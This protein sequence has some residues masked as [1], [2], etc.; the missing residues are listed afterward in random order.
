V[1]VA[2]TTPEEDPSPSADAPQATEAP[3]DTPVPELP[4]NQRKIGDLV[5]TV[6]GVAPYVDD[7]FPAEAGTHYVAVDITGENVGDSSYGLNALNFR[8]QDS[9]GFAN[10]QAVTQGPEPKIS[11][12]DLVPGQSV[13]GFIVFKLGDGRTPKELQY[14]SFTGTPG[15]IPIP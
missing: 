6:N 13:R 4:A 8:L 10:D 5:L 14:Q 12:H 7:L 9:D 11:H 1:T 2:C 15:T 3:E